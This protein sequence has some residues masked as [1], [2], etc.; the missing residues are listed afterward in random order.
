MNARGIT[1]AA[2]SAALSI[3]FMLI[4]NY[5]PVIRT[6]PL[7]LACAAMFIA[8]YAGKSIVGFLAMAA[9]LGIC[10]AFSGLSSTF[11]L[12]ALVFYPYCIVAYYIRNFDYRGI[13]IPLRLAAVAAVANVGLAAMYFLTKYLFF[14]LAVICEFLGGYFTLACI[15]TAVFWVFDFI[16]ANGIKYFTKLIVRGRKK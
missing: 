4:S 6:T 15:Y 16:F 12:S 13:G 7:F 3:V 8:F 11:L 9:S 5:V 14:D 10:F 2:V 1:T